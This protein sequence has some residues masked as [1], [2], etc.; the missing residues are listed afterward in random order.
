MK[1]KKITNYKYNLLKLQL[2]K[3]KI[4][5]KSFENKN[6]E[7][8]HPNVIIEQTELELKKAIS[9]I[10]R[11]HLNKKTIFFV[12]MPLI[13]HKKFSKFLK[14][15]RH[16]S[17][18]EAIWVNGILSNKNAIFQSFKLKSLKHIK[19]PNYKIKKIKPLFHIDKKPNLIVII[20]P[21]MENNVS[22]EANKLRIPVI[23]LNSHLLKNSKISF[24]ISGNFKLTNKKIYNHICLILNLLFK[25]TKLKSN[26]KNKKI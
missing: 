16:L 11:Y 8:D 12:G 1:I 23:G 24:K 21:G 22:K 7:T 6:Y 13:L 5:K 15:T 17:I 26:T 18:P 9:I 19:K 2:I 14:K 20:N 3:S 25:K 10:H 4:Y